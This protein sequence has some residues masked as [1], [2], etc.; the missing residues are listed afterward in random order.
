MENLNE[1]NSETSGT[2]DGQQGSSTPS[3]QTGFTALIDKKQIENQ[4]S[5]KTRVGVNTDKELVWPQD[6][7]LDKGIANYDR[8]VDIEKH[9]S[10]TSISSSPSVANGGP[11][12]RPPGPD[13]GLSRDRDG[14]VYPEGG[15][16]AYLVVVGSLVALFGSSG[17]AN[18]LGT[19]MAW[20]ST[21]Q[22]K[23]HSHSSISW[24]FGVYAFLMFFA[25]IQIGPIF[26]AKGPRYLIFAGSVMVVLSISLLGLCTEYWH[27]MVVWGIIG[28]LGSSLIFTPAVASPGHFFYRLRGRATGIATTGGS[29]GGVL[30]PLML[31]DLFPKL[32]FAWATR[33]A[34]LVTIISVG[35]G[36]IFI[37]SRLPK[38]KATK[39]NILP[40]FRILRDPEFALTTLGVFFIELGF[41]V[42]ITYISAYALAHGMSEKF[43]YQV[44]AIF[45]AGSFFGR[46]I[47]G[48]TADY[49]GR[50]NTMIVTLIICFLSCACL[51]LPAQDSIAM[52]VAYALI[53]GF[54]SGSTISLTPVCISQCCK[55]EHYGRY[56]ATSYT[57]VSIGSLTGT[58]IA[59]LILTH[60]GGHYWGLITFTIVCNFGALVCFIIIKMARHGWNLWAFY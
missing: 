32:G 52:L 28:G 23:D 54:G 26:D 25:G 59:G 10:E 53:F 36:C 20:I 50:V 30:Y 38:K 41:F 6:I 5:E 60:N 44:P 15:L 27:F 19:F 7:D 48:F 13:D 55:L 29:L 31:Q 43:S 46:W 57:I 21:H 11:E 39:E 35:I 56:Y 40:D 49:M 17:L 14:N 33:A 34:A 16:E 9:S 42:P 8:E 4:T 37:R 3:A 45:N 12:S 58:P 47:P 2:Q 22:L 51:W 18:S 24:I 1:Y